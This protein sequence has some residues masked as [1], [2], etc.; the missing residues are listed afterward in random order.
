MAQTDS[1]YIRGSVADDMHL[2]VIESD[3]FPCIGFQEKAEKAQKYDQVRITLTGRNSGPPVEFQHWK[4]N[5][6]CGPLPPRK[7]PSLTALEGIHLA[8][9]FCA[10]PIAIL[11]GT[12]QIYNVIL[13][14]QTPISRG[15]RTIKTVFGYG[16][17]GG[18]EAASLLPRRHTNYRQKVDTLWDLDS[19][20][21]TDQEVKD[22]KSYPEPKWNEEVNA[23][24]LILSG[25]QKTVQ[26]TTYDLQE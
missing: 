22:C 1:S 20:G 14:N 7:P 24:K 15:L 3:T 13:W 12:D 5:L 11:I 26:R 6:L 2:P 19:L 23:M 16:I 17:H 25:I 4:T 21:I 9:D 10:G 8:D 18:A